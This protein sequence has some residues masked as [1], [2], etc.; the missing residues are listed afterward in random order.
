MNKNM[1]VGMLTVLMTAC[2]T[3]KAPQPHDW[4][5]EV[6]TAETREAHNRLAEHYEEIAKTMEA[7]AAE[8]KAMLDKYIGSPHKYGKQIIDIK[9]RSQ[10]MIHDFELAAGESRKMAAYHRQLANVAK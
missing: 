4:A 5:L 3:N 2:A 9:A 1:I 8:E 7:D 6:Q 10:A